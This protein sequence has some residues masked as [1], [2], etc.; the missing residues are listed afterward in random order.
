MLLKAE[1]VN[2][3]SDFRKLVQMEHK[4]LWPFDNR[5]SHVKACGLL[6][7]EKRSAYVSINSIQEESCLGTP[8]PKDPNRVYLLFKRATMQF[9]HLSETKQVFRL[10]NNIDP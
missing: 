6:V 1:I 9:E 4:F 5:L 7:P 10:M 8:F 3:I 2:E